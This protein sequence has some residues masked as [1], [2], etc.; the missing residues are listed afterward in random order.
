MS[1]KYKF[2]NP[3]AL[4]FCTLTVVRWIDLFS[5][6]AYRQILLENLKFCQDQKGLHVC[7]YVVMTNHL[8]LLVWVEPRVKIGAVLR[9]FKSFSAKN[10]LQAIELEGESRRDWLLYLF[11][12]HA[13]R[14]KASQQLQLWVH[15]SHPIEIS[16]PQ[17]A[18]QKLTYIH[19]NPVRAGWV[20][21]PEEWV[22]SSASNYVLGDGV[23]EVDLLPPVLK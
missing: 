23:L 5:R 2:H 12:N 9:D 10:I 1:N 11:R 20:R 3:D 8:H 21:H 16:S 17:M 6:M 4:Y 14:H 22:Y 18:L 13:E 15:D 7:G 19:L